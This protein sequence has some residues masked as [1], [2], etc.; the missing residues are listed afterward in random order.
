MVWDGGGRRG[1]QRGWGRE[2]EV[3]GSLTIKSLVYKWL[4]HI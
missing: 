2:E 1:G 3:G 4:F